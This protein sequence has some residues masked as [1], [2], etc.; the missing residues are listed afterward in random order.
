M[1]RAHF[2]VVL[3]GL[4]LLVSS[5]A[6]MAGQNVFD[7][8]VL[9]PSI[10]LVD[11]EGQHVVN[12][13]KPYS[14]RMSCGNG[15][16]G[17]CH[18]IDKIS[19]AY[20]FEMGRDEAADGYG[21][22]LG[23]DQLVSPGFFGGYNCGYN[24]G[25]LNTPQWLAKKV[26]ASENEFLDYGA[27]GLIKNCA[28]CHNGGGFAEKDRDGNQYQKMTASEI[29]PLDG[30]YFDWL[31]G[32]SSN[33]P[34]NVLSKWNWQ[35]SGVIEP[36]C[37]ICHADFAKFKK[38]ANE[39]TDLRTKQF[40]N[41]GLFRYANSAIF[42]FLNVSPSSADGKTLL[43]VP[44]GNDAEGQP[45]LQWNAA[46][47]DSNLKVQIPMLR[48]PGD[49][50]CMQCHK[51]SHNR[52]GF[53]GFGEVSKEEKAPDGTLIVDY[54]DD[55]H[56]G[57]LWNDQGRARYMENC[58]SCHSKQYYKDTFR[59]VDLDADHNFLIGNSDEDVRKDLNFQ[60]GPLSCEYCHNG[61]K[62]GGAPKPALPSGHDNILD[63]HRELW[64][65]NGDMVGYPANS[66]NKVT[67]VHLDVIACQTC[68]IT[69]LK[70]DGKDLK[71]RYRYREAEDGSLKM[72]PY[73][74]ASRY[75]WMDK[76]SKRVITRQ[77]ILSV[78][79]GVESAPQTYQAILALKVAFDD[80][81]LSKNY[82]KPDVQMIWTESN[83]YLISHNTRPA[84]SAMPCEECH[85]RKQNGSVS[86]LVEP[87]RILGKKN[88]SVVSEITDT[89][90]Y[91]RLVKDGVVKLDMPYFE[92]SKDG[93]I[94][95][96]VDEVLY[97]TKMDPFTS[98]LKLNSK[99]VAT[100][101]FKEVT[102]G[103]ALEI[104]AQ[105]DAAIFSAASAKL[106]PKVFLFNNLISG[107]KVGK[108]AIA[109]DFTS[110]SKTIVPNYRLEVA[111]NDWL[112]YKLTPAGKKP[113]KASN[114][115]AQGSVTSPVFN[116]QLQDQQRQSVDS[117][118]AS[119]L[120]VRLPYAGRAKDAGKVELFETRVLNDNQLA[121]L[122]VMKAEFIGVKPGTSVNP[123]YVLVS[124]D[125]LP[126]QLVLV[127]LK[128]AKK[129]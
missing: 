7:Q 105:D 52:R 23:L 71:I 33:N 46:A 34:G 12:S 75:Y 99:D 15:E 37:M 5:L 54:Q 120:L 79:K 123:G 107:D 124:V 81:L 117:L 43:T 121:P 108:L 3:M 57:K 38:P 98:V 2:F 78:N 72:M 44:G 20:H 13:K 94:I 103:E 22:K 102:K 18:D 100:G 86:S 16:G 48:F 8:P 28:E 128:K 77:E 125:R 127:D 26:N 4:F 80:L 39:W 19:H 64:K 118:G 45:V 21:K 112:T 110:A 27:P 114:L 10:P 106:T 95:E 96:N 91:A 29:K 104:V 1:K 42:A 24:P 88:V 41:K 97:E 76:I 122:T 113:K 51:T 93:K 83:E 53:Y 6:V 129:K 50:N 31:T 40:I 69:K 58:N 119:K 82:A 17:G 47:F 35:K 89:T 84:V 32:D 65:T 70:A 109:L 74:P 14:T 68:H 67:Q 85:A 87:D 116:F 30:D 73:K 36:D 11:E 126:E 101:E 92:V 62:F 63:A 60:P 61:P 115:I 25:Q 56:K 90:A 111:L 59:N 66:L 49:T 55:V 9:H